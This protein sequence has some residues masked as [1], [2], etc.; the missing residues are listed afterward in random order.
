M[1]L[2]EF[3]RLTRRH[4]GTIAA[5]TVLGAIVAA[6]L[7]MVLPARYTSQASAYVRVSVPK[8]A[9][10][11][12]DSNAYFN[13]SQLASEKVKAFVPLF[14][15][16]TVAQA[17][18]TQL[19]LSTTPAELASGLSTSNAANSLTIDVTA[20]GDSSEQSKKIADA[21]V[22]QSASQVR[23]LEGATS[24]VQV[25]ML[26]PASLS[27]T[28]KSP[29]PIKYLAAGVLAGLLLGYAFA[30]ARHHFDTRLR[31]ADDITE[32]FTTPILAVLPQSKA[33]ARTQAASEGDFH[34][35]E[36]LRKLRT[37]LRY[38]NVDHQARVILITS[39]QQNDGKSSVAANLAKV[40]AMAGDDVVIIDADLRR[41]SVADTYGIRGPLG[42]LQVLVGSAR[43]ENV[44]RPSRIAGLSI[45]PTFDT[46]PNPSELLGSDR[47][48]ELVKYLSR[49]RTVI[50]DAPPVLPVTDAV[51]LAH[52]AD[53]V[54]MVASAGR[55][56][57]EQLD[58]A[59]GAIERGEGDVAGVVLNRAAS[60]KLARLRYGDSEYGYASGSE[61]EYVRADRPTPSSD[62]GTAAP[63]QDSEE[64]SSTRR[65]PAISA[66]DSEPNLHANDHEG[67]RE[68]VHQTR[69]TT[70]RLKRAQPDELD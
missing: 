22:N 12:A 64:L 40:I 68:P 35:G 37:N 15:S 51:V 16:E 41:P 7:L 31:T 39:P 66:S 5:F 8:S 6:G 58:H 38:A 34:A 49:D 47:M 53:A 26:S 32:R 9:S 57:A 56:R 14:T 63:G 1:T 2:R 18:I 50:L 36:A 69:T 10:G 20:T 27:Q 54:V 52:L 62:R 3:F 60:S 67:S 29:S 17:V 46:P 43:V 24:P 55:T 13:A 30:L 59:L 65:M 23:R 4:L 33:I 28:T 48:A 44:L 45:L 11:T 70:R 19:G 25:V 42:L 21:V 61:S